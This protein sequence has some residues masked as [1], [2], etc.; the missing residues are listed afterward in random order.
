MLI[1]QEVEL[2]L[3]Q[4]TAEPVFVAVYNEKEQRKELIE[5]R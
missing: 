5:F 1:K 4:Q 2:P 3:Q